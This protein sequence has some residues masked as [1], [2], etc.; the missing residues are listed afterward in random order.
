MSLETHLP[1]SLPSRRLSL[2]HGPSAFPLSP[3]PP[4]LIE[5]TTFSLSY[6]SLAYN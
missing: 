1:S 3:F 2:R 4:F 6:A 5:L